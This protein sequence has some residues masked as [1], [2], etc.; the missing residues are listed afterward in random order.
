MVK[1]AAD[2]AYSE[3]MNTPLAGSR[4]RPSASPFRD[5]APR[6]IESYA[7]GERVSH[8]RYGMGRVVG[9]D[10]GNSIVVDFGSQT[11]RISSPYNKLIKL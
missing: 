2:S 3:V 1:W 6:I 9:V 7:V 10:E 5:P 4:R 11:L 8:D